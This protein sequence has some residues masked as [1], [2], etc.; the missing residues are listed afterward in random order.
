MVADLAMSSW[1]AWGGSALG[2]AFVFWVGACIGS[3]LNVVAYRLPR[4]EGLFS[5]PSRCPACETQL[6]WR[7]NLPIF[8]WLLLRGKCRFCRSPISP[9]YP[10]VE[11]VTAILF[12]FFFAAWFG[13]TAGRPWFGGVL[14]P[15]WAD[16]GIA[17]M[18]PMLALV[19]ATVA[20]LIAMT[21]ID[22]RTFMIPLSIPWFLT[23]IAI[24]THP[25]HAFW[26]DARGIAPARGWWTI[27]VPA[28][29]GGV[30]LALGG[31]VG[32]VAC[33]LLLKLR[34]IPRSFADFERWAAESQRNAEAHGQRP[35]EPDS[36][37]GGSAALGPLLL[38]VLYLTAPAITLMC[39]GFAVGL[40]IGLPAESTAA[41]AVI[42]LLVGVFMRRLAPGGE[43]GSASGS[44]IHEEPEWIKYPHARREATKELLCI[45]CI[46]L[47]AGVGWLLAGAALREAP[48]LWLRALAGAGAGY[49]IGGGIVWLVRIFG[50]I[51]FGKE[52]MGMGDVHLL[53]AVGAALGWL[54]P[55][56][57]FFTAPFFGIAW[58]IAAATLFRK[59]GVAVAMPFGPHLAAG[60]IAVLVAWPLYE[61]LVGTLLGTLTESP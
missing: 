1:W 34:V 6:R 17:R 40:Q 18:W 7:Q 47:G 45:A 2:T 4:G 24:L 28:G 50:T 5:P 23:A 57:A 60:A 41:G 53:A 31:L 44:G 20:S 49:L 37:D 12:A 13:E 3:F 30:G 11:L 27:P 39:L 10:I 16:E 56:L 22:A 21:L 54:D 42:G 33:A 46:L 59:K 61:R 15:A 32:V 48:P 38:R 36:L 55:V 14:Q 19:Y 9:Q 29:P 52:A 43:S 25:L 58:V 26:L 51:A 35:G 8:G